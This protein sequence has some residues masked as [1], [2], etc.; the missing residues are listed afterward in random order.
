MDITQV[1]AHYKN[2]VFSHFGCYNSTHINNSVIS[3]YVRN[4]NMP[5]EL[6]CTH[7]TNSST[8]SFRNANAL[9]IIIL[10]INILTLSNMSHLVLK[11]A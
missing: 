4:F 2:Y 10:N 8:Q 7:I 3:N 6:K 9:V 5:C 11:A 1:Y